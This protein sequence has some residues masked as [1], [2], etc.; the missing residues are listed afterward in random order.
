MFV[1]LFKA[2]A[3]CLQPLAV[4]LEL[5]DL[6]FERFVL[7]SER[8]VG[9][10]QGALRLLGFLHEGVIQVRVCGRVIPCVLSWVDVP[11]PL[12]DSRCR[13]TG[14]EN[15]VVPAVLT[16]FDSV[17]VEFWKSAV[18]YRRPT[19]NS[20][21]RSEQ[22]RG[23]HQSLGADVI[24][25]FRTASYPSTS[26]FCSPCVLSSFVNRPRHLGQDGSKTR[27]VHVI[28]G[29]VD[30]VAVPPRFRLVFVRR[31]ADLVR[32]VLNVAFL[33]VTSDQLTVSHLAPH[34]MRVE[35]GMGLGLVGSDGVGQ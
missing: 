7:R 17:G 33:V 2:R 1:F 14:M 35:L 15:A 31:Y 16:S 22:I 28:R 34:C 6:S 29:A 32:G 26:P 3:P 10:Q 5:F 19:G 20:R 23:R 21:A 25:I 11:P 8:L 13:E 30:S 27:I 18:S 4:L 12:N 24:P 9:S